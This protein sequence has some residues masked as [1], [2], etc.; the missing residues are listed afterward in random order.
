MRHGIR[1]CR[2]RMG[3][4]RCFRFCRSLKAVRHSK[5]SRQNEPVRVLSCRREG[6][7]S[8]GSGVTKGAR[9]K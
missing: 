6:D 2:D 5:A 9:L 3:F 7:D 4:C 1:F 8:P